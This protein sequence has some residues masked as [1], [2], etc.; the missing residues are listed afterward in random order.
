MPLPVGRKQALGWRSAGSAT[1]CCLETPVA[2]RWEG[3]GADGKVRLFPRVFVNR[4]ELKKEPS[5]QTARCG[6]VCEVLGAARGPSQV[7]DSI[8][9][10]SSGPIPGGGQRRSPA[11]VEPRSGADPAFQSAPWLPRAALILRHKHS[12][13][14]SGGLGVFCSQRRP[15]SPCVQAPPASQKRSIWGRGV[16]TPSRV[17]TWGP[18]VLSPPISE[19]RRPHTPRGVGHSA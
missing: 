19:A 18:G 11:E 8:G 3:W 10:R 5:F 2:T 16:S 17:C 13:G 1:G 9:H 6:D 12:H 7:L 4:K 14:Q 15:P